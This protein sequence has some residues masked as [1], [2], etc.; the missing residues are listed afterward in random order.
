V[1]IILEIKKGPQAGRKFEFTKPD[2]FMMGRTKQAHYKMSND[3]LYVSRRHFLIEI[4]PPN[5]YIRDLDSMNG[6]EINGKKIKRGQIKHG[7][8]IRVGDTI[9]RASML[10]T[11]EDEKV[12][13]NFCGK[14]LSNSISAHSEN[15]DAIC[16]SCQKVMESE[17][18]EKSEK[19]KDRFLAK[20]WDCG[21][22]LS[23]IA[24]SDG[25]ADELK[26][27]VTYICS[28]CA[29]K[30]KK[31][32]IITEIGDYQLLSLIGEGSIGEVYSAFHKQTSRLVA[33]KRI[34]F[35]KTEVPQKARKRFIREMRIMERL[36]HPNIVQ[37]IDQG[38][39]NGENY[40]IS[41]LMDGGDADQL[42]TQQYQGPV[43]IET[44]CKIIIE[45]L[46]SLEYFHQAQ[47]VHRDIKPQNILLSNIKNSVP[48]TI[49][50]AD[51]GLAKGYADAGG[52]TIT[53]FGEYNGSLLFMAPEQF[54]N[55]KDVPQTADVYSA[56]AS[57]YYLLSAKF[58]FD[59]PSPLDMQ[60][61]QTENKKPRDPVLIVLEDKPALIRSKNPDIPK[62]LAYVVD[63]AIRKEMDQR[64]C[65]AAELREEIQEK[66]RQV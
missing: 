51:F 20:C 38:I 52:S 2:S 65:S 11:E 44:A 15:E 46:N 33:L 62:A 61:A 58:P 48:E 36:S 39:F 17:K 54:V 43:P 30:R 37:L 19:V 12:L 66:M 13:C 25:R 63:R 4:V 45:V 8:I 32:V 55:F 26:E 34:L 3:D 56:G 35:N 42:V 1:K 59:F 7:D 16:P 47:N 6:T 21:A 50:L 64:F 41:E 10:L 28:N 22:D 18:K 53:E 29:D 49:K 14:T 9:L 40:L 27:I 24:N 31:P 23:D 60:R 5:C 57:L